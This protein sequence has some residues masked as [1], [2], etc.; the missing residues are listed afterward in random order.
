MP[1]VTSGG[2][3]L[4][5]EESGRGT[6]IVFMHEFADDLRGSNVA[7]GGTAG[8]P[9]RVNS[10]HITSSTGIQAPWQSPDLSS[11]LKRSHVRASILSSS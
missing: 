4:Y 9:P 1:Y 7:L 11:S 3:R 10:N 8:Q 2:V 5:Y 6:P